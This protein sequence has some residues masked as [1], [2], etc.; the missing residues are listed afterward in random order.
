VQDA[1]GVLVAT[2]VAGDAPWEGTV[3]LYAAEV[4]L[5]A[6]AEGTEMVL[7]VRAEGTASPVAHTP[8]AEVVRLP[9]APA[10]RHRIA[11]TVTDAE[12]GAPIPR[13]KVVAHP[14]R[15]LADAEGRAVLDVAPGEHRVF[16]SG[17]QHFAFN[18]VCTVAGDVDLSASLH[19]DR[20]LT[21]EDLWS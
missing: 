10:A 17:T 15:T 8:R 7:T 11:V 1:A 2:G 20:E 19:R 9:V 14:Y 6:P 12:T 4:V 13:A 5:T 3:G 21:H 16:A 18:T